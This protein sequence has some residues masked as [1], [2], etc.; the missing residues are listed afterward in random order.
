MEMPAV[1]TICAIFRSL[2]CSPVWV[3]LQLF[4]LMKM[5]RRHL[6]LPR[7]LTLVRTGSPLP[8]RSGFRSTNLSK[9]QSPGQRRL[10]TSVLIEKQVTF[11]PNLGQG[12]GNGEGASG[13]DCAE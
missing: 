8:D 4:G 5:E 2:P 3:T 7:T 10:Q 13:R 9:H 11:L 1:F 12:S 6:A